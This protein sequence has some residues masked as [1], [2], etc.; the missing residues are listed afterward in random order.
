MLAI[1]TITPLN[2]HLDAATNLG[3]AAPY[4]DFKIRRGNLKFRQEIGQDGDRKRKQKELERMNAKNQE[5][6]DRF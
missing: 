1:T 2:A 3:L 4:S 5:E 6:R